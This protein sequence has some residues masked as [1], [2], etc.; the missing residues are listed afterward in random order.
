MDYGDRVQAGP[1][2]TLANERLAPTPPADA[3]TRRPAERGCA[4]GA[5][6]CIETKAVLLINLSRV[7]QGIRVYEQAARQPEHGAVNV[8]QSIDLADMY[9]YLGRPSDALATLISVEPNNMSVIGRME[10]DQAKACAYAQLNDEQNLG[11]T[12]SYMRAHREDDPR[13][14]QWAEIC[15]NDVES[16][17][18]QLILSLNDPESRQS[19]LL[20]VQS[21]AQPRFVPTYLAVL[22]ARW[23]SV[24]ARSDVRRA[25]VQIGRADT[26]S[27]LAERLE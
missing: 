16:A 13:A 12:L 1:K 15:A 21:F 9:D 27:Q 3:S 17:A 19:A 26:Y 20:S 10:A 8:S 24:V 18:Q 22:R 25:I 14:T 7:D 11:A 23:R 5:N 4:V 2:A 6:A